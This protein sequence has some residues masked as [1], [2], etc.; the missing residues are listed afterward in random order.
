MIVSSGKGPAPYWTQDKRT[1]YWTDSDE[2]HPIHEEQGWFTGN[3][4]RSNSLDL[5]R[6]YCQYLCTLVHSQGLHS[7]LFLR[8]L[9]AATNVSHI[10]VQVVLQPSIPEGRKRRP[11]RAERPCEVDRTLAG[12]E[13]GQ[14]GSRSVLV[15]FL[16]VQDEPRYENTSDAVEMHVFRSACSDS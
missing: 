10:R 4:T 8:G 15:D 2:H 14:L 12:R 9:V 11:Q 6:V 13:V 3:P 5:L 16:Q 1:L 7:L